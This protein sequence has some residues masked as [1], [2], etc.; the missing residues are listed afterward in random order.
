VSLLAFE[1]ACVVVVAL[2][3]VVMA[4]ARGAGPVLRDYA[5]LAV[6]GFVGE[7][8]CIT[9]YHFYAYAPGWH[10]RVVDVPALVPLIWPLVVLS[11]RDVVAA[12]AP[13][14]KGGRP[15]AV[16]LLVALDASLVEV[17]AVRAGL[18][19]WAEPGHLGVPVIGILGW[20][21]FAAGAEIAL[22]RG[23][24]WL[25]VVT[26]PLVAHALIQASWWGLFR[27]TVR[28]ALGTTSVA[29][30]ALIGLSLGSS[31]WLL[32]RA[33][34]SMPLAVAA[35]RMIAASLFLV[36]L[37]RTAPTEAPLWIHTLAVALPYFAVTRL[38]PARPGASPAETAT[39][40]G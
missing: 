12:L 18:W 27:W 32:R 25:A 19:S 28:G 24:A 35:P 33:G 23:R 20:G 6:A 30:T 10:A 38:A 3:L 29:A 36:L 13:A 7:E 15:L 37:V 11:A 1:L 39:T 9:L 2:T 21:Y 34:K 4:R 40:P 5:V 14:K 8:T 17:V 22:A 16:A 26:G 31:A